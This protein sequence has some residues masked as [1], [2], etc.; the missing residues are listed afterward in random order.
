MLIQE[1]TTSWTL[2]FQCIKTILADALTG[3]A[4]SFEHV[5]ST[6]VPGLAAKPIIDIDIILANRKDFESIKEKLAQI[7][8]YHNGDQGIADREVFKRTGTLTLHNVLDRIAHHLYV[9]PAESEELKRHLLFRNYLRSNKQASNEYQ[10]L[11]QQLAEEAN[12]DRKLYAQLK[13]E[14]AFIESILAKANE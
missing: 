12:H 5:G 11:K 1:Y 14:K 9:C 2:N 3:I 8:Y 6:A 10:Q 13:E 4:V 7:G